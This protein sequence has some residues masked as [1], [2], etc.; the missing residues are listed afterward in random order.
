MFNAAVR[1]VALAA[2]AAVRPSRSLAGRAL[3]TSATRL[4]GHAPTPQLFGEGAKAGEV[5]SDENQS[6]GIERLQVLAA[7]EGVE[8]FDFKP[9]D[10]SRIGTLAEPIKVLSW[11]PSRIVGCT[12][13]PAESHELQWFNLTR[14]KNR[15][16]PECGSVY[17]LDFQGE[18]HGHAHAH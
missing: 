5:P 2:R 10:S 13:S 8:V 15:R 14:Q 7:K 16:C 12:G 18:E 9:L 11:E 4:S 6:T 3:S 1:P 17:T